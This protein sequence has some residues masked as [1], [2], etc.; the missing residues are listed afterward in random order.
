MSE[1]RK[2]TQE[3]P[4]I[5]DSNMNGYVVAK[6]RSGSVAPVHWSSVVDN[7]TLFTEWM[8]LSLLQSPLTV[9]KGAE[10]H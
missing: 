1:F 8:P 5:S 3:L 9:I 6:S 10:V 4:K 2:T 7:P